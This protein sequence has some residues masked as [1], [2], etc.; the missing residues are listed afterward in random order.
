LIGPELST[1]GSCL[2]P[3]EIVESIL[4][5]RRTVKEGYAC[6]SVATSDGKVRQGYKLSETPAE[7]TFRDPTSE[8]QFKVSK[9]EIEEIRQD[10]SLMPDGL[11]ATMSTAEKRDLVRFLLEMGH[12]GGAAAAVHLARH[13]AVP[14]MF[15]SYDPKPL[16][17][18]L[19]PSWQLPANRNRV[20][21]WYAKQA[22][23]FLKQ[24]NP[25]FLL[26]VYPGI[27]GGR[28]PE[29]TEG[30]KPDGRWNQADLGTVLCGVFRGAGVTIPKA[31]CVR[32]GDQRELAVCFNPETLCYEALWRDGFF[33]FSTLRHG[34]MD[35]LRMN[36]TALPRPEGKK[37]DK[38]FVY[39]GFYRHGKRVIFAYRL[40]DT[41]MLD[42]P[43][44]ENGQFTR[45]LAP[46][47]E[48]PMR[49]MVRGGPPQWPQVLT[50]RGTLGPDGAGPYVVDTI[51]PPFVN[52]WNAPM[53][54]GDHD[55]LSDGTAMLC[56]MEGDVWRVDGL[57]ETLAQVHWRR[58][59]T[60]LHQAL[61]LVIAEGQIYVVGRDQITRLHD[62]NG[63]GE[64]DF[65]ECFS[66]AYRTSTFAHDFL[67]GL[68]RDAQGRFYTASS[69]LGLLR[70][71]AD[72][73][74]VETLATGFRNPDGI[75]MTADGT[76]TVPNSQGQWVP[77]SMICEVRPG[78]HFGYRGPRGG[79][80]PALPLVY[81][82]YGLDNSSSGQVT[83]PDG[84][85]GPLEGQLLH[86]SF[87]MGAWFLVLREKVDGQPQG[88]VMTMPGE[89]VSGAHRIRFNPK[90]GQLYAT[91]MAGWGTHTSAD[92]CFQRV[93][94][95]GA[96]VQLPIAYHVHENGV[97]VT[98]SRPVERDV[99]ER[100]NQ[101]LV[102]AWN[103]RYSPN[104]GSPELSARH[105][106][107]PGH[108]LLTVTSAHVLADG[109]TLFLEIPELQPV[110]QLHLHMRPDSGPPIDLFGTV[111]RLAAPFTG[112]P[113]YHAV[114]KTIGA[115]PILAD[116]VA[117]SRPPLRNP[118]RFEIS[119]AR[120][121]IIE[122][123]TNLSFTVK[124]FK[125]RAG[126]PIRFRF[127]NPDSVPHNW[128]LLKPG[129][130]AAVGDL[131]N[132][133]IAEPDAA[134]RHYI[135]KT[136]LVLFYTDIVEPQTRATIY[137]KA[138]TVPGRYPYI[139][140]FPGHWMV[141][142]GEMIVE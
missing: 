67:C 69:D 133:I 43:W 35:G 82:P 66:N 123:G 36:G 3:E 75:G 4:W 17:P 50:T 100:P 137:F 27:Y 29:E 84:R 57:D 24:P 23:Y 49:E 33:K 109:R 85:F 72:G 135:P 18:D 37:P 113:G 112:F 98:F 97:L 7:L 136:D 13:S 140:T 45:T 110:N 134:Y 44:V 90:D 12:P 115:H 141:M 79:Q 127:N 138:P 121:V 73:R 28:R 128:A 60:G 16:R 10:G 39:H 129:S 46:A 8:A 62:L 132:R 107:H 105:P 2:K 51:E 47:A 77:C 106:G 52:P 14:A 40:G 31:V 15:S 139:C 65:Y 93:R 38:P 104:Y 30:D 32:I 21:D 22:E 86:S 96:P 55:F 41:E 59:A 19:W 80:P 1:V 71:S 11:A 74:S 91:G 20:Y 99:A 111:H 81:I 126:E 108:D 114:P 88:A 122:A 92:G 103:Y 70:V 34:F 25:P 117:L 78:D 54:F 76:I 102:Q 5:P 64:A 83:V 118:N 130:M 119:G 120:T 48:H 61:G 9:A 63:D 58:F 87:G 89:F 95:T 68:E 116:M 101:H 124:S 125:V 56:T 26:P 94:Y 131:V 53:F 142:N 6:V 42:S